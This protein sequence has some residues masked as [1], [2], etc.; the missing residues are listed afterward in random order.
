MPL[1]GLVTTTSRLVGLVQLLVQ[2]GCHYISIGEGPV[3]ILGL[4]I[5]RGYKR[6]GIS[7]HSLPKWERYRSDEFRPRPL[8]GKQTESLPDVSESG[9]MGTFGRH[10]VNGK[11]ILP[12][13]ALALPLLDQKTLAVPHFARNCEDE[14]DQLPDAHSSQNEKADQDEA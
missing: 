4:S 12:G 14:I 11:P 3:D 5:R 9:V 7:S 8:S 13:Y 1:Y 6:M 10:S 2:Q